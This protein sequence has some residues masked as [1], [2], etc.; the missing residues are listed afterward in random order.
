MASAIH[1]YSL[2]HNLIF[3]CRFHFGCFTG[4]YFK[5]GDCCTKSFGGWASSRHALFVSYSRL[6]ENPGLR[7]IELREVYR[8]NTILFLHWRWL[9]MLSVITKL[10]WNF[11]E[12]TLGNEAVGAARRHI[13]PLRLD[14]LACWYTVTC[15]QELFNKASSLLTIFV[16][17]LTSPESLSLWTIVWLSGVGHSLLHTLISSF[18]R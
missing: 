16:T 14:V 7:I 1:Q 4:I 10:S 9:F 11:H 12:A 8:N 2:L 15:I 18:E 6:S 17:F 3:S 5:F 13:Y